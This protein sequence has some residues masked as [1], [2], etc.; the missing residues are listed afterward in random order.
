MSYYISNINAL[1]PRLAKLYHALIVK[2]MERKVESKGKVCVTGAS[3]F[4]ASWLVKRLLL[5]GYHVTGT[6]RDPG[7]F[8]SNSYINHSISPFFF[9]FFF[10]A[11]NSLRTRLVCRIIVCRV[12]L[13]VSLYNLCVI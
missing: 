6:V 3:G 9:S 1:A 4:L 2:A 13:C 7:L 5:S 11:N 10:S 8:I 12:I